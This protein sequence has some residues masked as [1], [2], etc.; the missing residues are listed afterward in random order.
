[1]KYSKVLKGLAV[2]LATVGLVLPLPVSALAAGP[3]PVRRDVALGPGGLFRGQLVDRQGSGL[4][5]ATVT[6]SRRGREV[7]SG[8]TDDDGNFA[9]TKLRGG[10]YQVQTG[11]VT[12]IY[13]LW[14]SRSAPPSA[15]QS[16]L[17]VTDPF[18]ARGQIPDGI[19]LSVIALGVGMGAVLW[20]AIDHNTS[21]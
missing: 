10:V 4:S 19:P 18:V 7:A 1:M 21:S 12:G 3:Q 5:G 14:A 2:V 20:A 8:I 6:V 13:R 16:V 9:I 11:Q 15:Q 17:L